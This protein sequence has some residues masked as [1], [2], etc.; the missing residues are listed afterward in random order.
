LIL[1][2]LL[3]LFLNNHKMS[4]I[5]F[6]NVTKKYYEYSVFDKLTLDLNAESINFFNGPVGSGKSTFIKLIIGIIKPDTGKLIVGGN[7]ML[8]IKKEKLTDLRKKIGLISRELKL[9]NSYTVQENI[10]LPLLF[11]GIEYE[12]AKKRSEI[13]IDLVNLKKKINF[14]P[15]NLTEGELQLTRLARAIVHQPRLVLADEPFTYLDDY[16]KVLFTEII[17]SYN[18]TGTTFIITSSVETAFF[19]NQNFFKF[20]KGTIFSG[21]NKG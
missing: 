20:S 21:K 15:K 16:N 2:N 17:K 5:S 1:K 9:I 3:E 4:Y 14:F 19:S 6:K 10:I 12:E 13:I 7:D 18:R 8:R 11:L